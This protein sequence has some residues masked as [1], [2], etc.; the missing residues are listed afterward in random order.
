VC[1][2]ESAKARERERE[3]GRGRGR[4]L[5]CKKGRK[6]S[7]YSISVCDRATECVMR[8]RTVGRWRM[9]GERQ[10]RGERGEKRGRE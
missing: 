8:K 2:V 6:T 4:A 7:I 10:K 5:E 1:D 9:C 3:R